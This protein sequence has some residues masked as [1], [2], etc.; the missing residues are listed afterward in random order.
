MFS[1]GFTNVAS[2]VGGVGTTAKLILVATVE[3]VI[4]SIYLKLGDT[5]YTYPFP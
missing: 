2:Y 5:S 3:G 1:E 4:S